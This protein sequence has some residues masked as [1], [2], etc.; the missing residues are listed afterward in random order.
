MWTCAKLSTGWAFAVALPLLTLLPACQPERAQPTTGHAALAP[1]I[2]ENVLV[3]FTQQPL[4]AA[5]LGAGQFGFYQ[6]RG[7]ILCSH[8][9]GSAQ[10]SMQVDAFTLGLGE[11]C[12]G[13]NPRGFG[14][15][16]RVVEWWTGP[17]EQ[18]A[19]RHAQGWVVFRVTPDGRASVIRSSRQ[20]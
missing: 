16:T 1:P 11:A 17:E 8:L 15:F 9:F 18:I 5:R 13:S 14:P 6:P 20:T 12:A 2:P 10:R 7:D 19:V 4:D 3:G